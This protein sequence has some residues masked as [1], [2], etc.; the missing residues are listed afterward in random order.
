MRVICN[1]VDVLIE[2]TLMVQDKMV[3]FLVLVWL[4]WKMGVSENGEYDRIHASGFLI[5]LTI[6]GC[7]KVDLGKLSHEVYL[8]LAI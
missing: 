8:D 6:V 4:I 1:T 7:T 2:F 3:L 5:S